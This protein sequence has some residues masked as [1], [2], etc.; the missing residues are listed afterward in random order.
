MLCLSVF[1]TLKVLHLLVPCC[2]ATTTNLTFHFHAVFVFG[3]SDCTCR[4]CD[5]LSVRNKIIVSSLCDDGGHPGHGSSL[6]KI[7]PFLNYERNSD[8]LVWHRI[9]FPVLELAP[10][11]F[12]WPSFQVSCRT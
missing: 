4:A 10:H 5:W 6:M 1:S 12:P 3:D 11:R 2:D 9:S 8:V 7:L